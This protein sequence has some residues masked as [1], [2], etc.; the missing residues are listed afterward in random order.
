[1][2]GRNKSGHDGSEWDGA[3]HMQFSSVG[4]NGDNTLTASVVGL[5]CNNF[6]RRLRERESRAVIHAALDAGIALF[7]TA[8]SYGNG[9]SERFLGNALGPRRR[10]VLI[11]TK[12]GWSGG[13][14]RRKVAKAVEGSLKR[15][16]TDVIDLYQLHRPDP[17]TPIEETLEALDTL[18][19]QGKVRF[20]GCSNFSGEQIGRASA[21]SRERGWCA[22]VTAQN[23]W[24]VLERHIE[25]DVVPACADAGMGIL[26]YY[27]L[28]NGLLT[29]KYRRGAEW[30]RGT[31]LSAGF[32]SDS[33]WEA[34]ERLERFAAARGRSLLE[35]A[36]SWLACQPGILSVIAGATSA[37]QV[38]RNVKAAGWALTADEL[39]EIGRLT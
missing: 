29:G 28:A 13:A 19:R 4:R 18:V 21:V 8:E 5:G 26:P 23:P 6:G 34:V 2:D 38:E 16:R 37:E 12:F 33:R 30:P 11:A 3:W 14:S 25:D 27:P 35:L 17:S 24:S 32:V 36:V 31:R 9:K 7:D 20:V 22:F 39:A 10:D 1:M 15:L